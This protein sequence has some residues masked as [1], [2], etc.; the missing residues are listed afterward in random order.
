[1]KTSGLRKKA[2][3]RLSNKRY[4]KDKTSTDYTYVGKNNPISRTVTK[5]KDG[6][7]RVVWKDKDGNIIKTKGPEGTIKIRKEQRKRDR[8]KKREASNPFKS[9]NTKGKSGFGQ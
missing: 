6:T 5:S 3:K 8:K 7:K 2:K 9:K 1:M 4:K